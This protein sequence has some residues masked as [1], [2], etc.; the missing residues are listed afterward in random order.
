MFMGHLEYVN[1]V[2]VEGT[3]ITG[4]ACILQVWLHLASV[5]PLLTIKVPNLYTCTSTKLA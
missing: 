2:G 4:V 1:N 3:A 5:G